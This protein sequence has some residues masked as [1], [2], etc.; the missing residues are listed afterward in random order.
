ML[1]FDEP[2]TFHIAL[3]GDGAP[4]GKD[5]SACSWLISFLNIGHIILSSKENY[6]LF[7][8][9]CSENCLPVGLFQNFCQILGI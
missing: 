2:N 1:S 6:L 7:G 8:G 3:G 9:N 4:S 5:D